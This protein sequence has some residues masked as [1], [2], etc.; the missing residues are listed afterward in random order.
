MD[1]EPP[2]TIQT[3]IE[4]ALNKPLAFDPGSKY[5]YSNLGYCIL[6][7]VIEKVTGTDYEDYVQFA[8]LHPLGIYDMHIGKSFYDERFPSE[9]RYYDQDE[10]TLVWSYNGSRDLVPIEYGGNDI[11]LLG[12]AGGWLAS[13]PELAKLMVAIDDFESRPD[14]LSENSIDYMTQAKDDTRKLVGWRGTDGY[15]TWWRTGT[16][17]GTT[18]LIMRHKNE[19]YWVVLLNTTTEKR[20]KIHNELSRSMFKALRKVKK[21]PEYDLFNIESEITASI[22]N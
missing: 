7:E 16:L 15:G 21:W 6:G 19:V 9:V 13:A 4:Y 1:V 18:A 3:V 8:I 22:E 5:C 10:T 12:A 17:T 14:I 11:E 20:K 2:A